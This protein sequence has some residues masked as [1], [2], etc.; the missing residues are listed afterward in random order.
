MKCSSARAAMS[1]PAF[2]RRRARESE[3]IFGGVGAGRVIF[4]K[5]GTVGGEL[6]ERLEGGRKLE[7]FEDDVM[8]V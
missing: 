7:C 3:D 4:G 5:E 2:L 8:R 6:R 1:W